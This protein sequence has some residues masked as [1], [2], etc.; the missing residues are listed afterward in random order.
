M[1][2]W[3]GLMEACAVV[4]LGQGAELW[5]SSAVAAGLQLELAGL[6]LSGAGLPHASL[7]AC[8]APA[9]LFSISCWELSMLLLLRIQFHLWSNQQRKGR[10]C[11]GT[12]TGN[13]IY[14]WNNRFLS[15]WEF[16]TAWKLTVQFIDVTLPCGCVLHSMRWRKA[17]IVHSGWYFSWTRLWLCSLLSILLY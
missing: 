16:K 14:F 4:L 17:G 6:F 1:Q 2:T 13:G 5:W 12:V 9:A 10:L 7:A 3:W 11:V 8:S 15:V